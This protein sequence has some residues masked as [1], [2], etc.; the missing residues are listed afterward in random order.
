MM[1]RMLSQLPLPLLSSGAAERNRLIRVDR[2]TA[3]GGGA[4]GAQPGDS[5]EADP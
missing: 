3:H 2:M 1:A 4:D 5:A